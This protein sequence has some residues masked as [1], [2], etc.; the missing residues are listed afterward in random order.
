MPSI[1]REPS[2]SSGMYM[3]PEEAADARFSR[4]PKET[5]INASRIN[6]WLIIIKKIMSLWNKFLKKNQK[7]SLL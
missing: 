3:N 4:F 1:F 6:Q 2:F 5:M 7:F